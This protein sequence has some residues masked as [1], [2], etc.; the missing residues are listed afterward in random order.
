MMQYRLFGNSGLRVS[1]LCLGTMVFGEEWGNGA[2]FETSKKIFETYTSA[3]GNF[4]DTAN[5]YTEGTSEKFIGDF[6]A[7]D[8]DR[9]VLATKYSL[10]D[11]R[12]DVNATGNHRKNLMRSVHESLERLQTDYIDLLWLHMWDFTTPVEEVMRGLDD[13]IRM[14]VVHYV[15]IS[16]TPAW[17]VAK[18]NTMADFR[19]WTPFAGIQVEYS[20]IQRTAERDLIPMAKHFGLAITPW[21]PL[22]AGMLTGKHNE[23]PA[24][25][26]RLKATSVKMNERNLGIARKVTD[27]AMQMGCTPS[28]LALAWI[29]SKGPEFLPIIGSRS[30]SQ[31]ADTLACLA[32]NPE[33][34]VLAALDEIS[35]IDYGFPHDFYKSPGLQDVLY[36]DNKESFTQRRY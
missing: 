27:L 13:L 18:A 11:K 20:L 17:I 8:R 9:F 31:I 26:A 5:R 24:E 36:A 19:S 33:A 35:A 32:I 28:Q 12:N 30:E 3:G 23:K 6:I 21:A 7:A 4:I 22:G 16:D 34:E 15:G 25:G 10:F 1:E 29:R 2:N 14:G